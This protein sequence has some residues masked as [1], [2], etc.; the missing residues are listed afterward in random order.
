M[1]HQ[2]PDLSR[3]ALNTIVERHLE[4]GI[5]SRQPKATLLL[6]ESYTK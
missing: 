4:A 3:L 2:P 1:R 6:K 5:G